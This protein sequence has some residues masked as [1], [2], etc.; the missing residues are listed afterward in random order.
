MPQD[1]PK[2]YGSPKELISAMMDQGETAGAI[3]SAL[4]AAGMLSGSSGP[5]DSPVSVPGVEAIE[6]EEPMATD[7]GLPP[8]SKM[9]PSE[10]RMA[11]AELGI[12][13]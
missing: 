1:N 2:A 7:G 4:S 10:A 8:I 9:S 13:G 12:K 11:A 5:E 6:G 3:A